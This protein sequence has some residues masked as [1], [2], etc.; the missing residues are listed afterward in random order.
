MKRSFV[1]LVV[2]C[3]THVIFAQ[4]NVFYPMKEN[5]QYEY[6]H[7]DKKDKLTMRTINKF[8]NVT[9]SGD[10]MKA[11]VVQ[12]IIDAKK[13]KPMGSSDSEWVCENGTLHCTFNSLNLVEST[14]QENN[15]GVTVEIGGDKLDIPSNIKVGETMKDISYNV[16]MAMSGMTL[17]NRTYKVK[18][19]KIESEESITTPAGTFNCMKIT[20]ITTNE[21]GNNAIKSAM[22]YAKDSGLVKS[23]NYKDDGKLI[24]RQVLTK[25]VGR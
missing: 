12:E 1:T 24:G 11:T 17:F 16:K 6:E 19:R 15:P 25:I 3:F 21:K 8:K 23:E 2:V 9:G 18:D 4:C 13:D 5:V 7:F 20:F 22:W 14:G 10:Y